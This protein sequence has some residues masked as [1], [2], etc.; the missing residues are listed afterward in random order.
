MAVNY[1]EFIGSAERIELDQAMKRI[2]TALIERRADFLF[3]AGMSVQAPSSV[4][5]GRDLAVKLLEEYFPDGGDDAKSGDAKCPTCGGKTDIPPRKFRLEDLATAL[6]FEC[7]AEAIENGPGKKRDDLTKY[8]QQLLFNREFK[9]NPAHHEFLTVFSWDGHARLRRVFTTNF[10]PLIELALGAHAVRVTEKNA[11]DIDGIQERKQVPVLHLHGVLDEDY[12]ITESDVFDEEFQNLHFRLR[13][14]L[15][16]S[17]VF[18]F[19]GYSMSD[20]DFRRLYLRHR[21][22]LKFRQQR[23][24]DAYVVGPA[25]DHYSYVLAKAVWE[26]RYAIFLPLDAESFFAG[27]KYFLDRS[28]RQEIQRAIMK[29]YG[30]KDEK[31]FDDKVNNAADILQ[32]DKAEATQF[33]FEARTKTGARE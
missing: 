29:K 7:I 5:A 1:P 33:L 4:P 20:P 8:L 26:S 14:A 24:K 28:T 2:A 9:I 18:V 22:N 13:T 21:D 23:K 15:D 31:A 17:D 6:P 3:G 30:L 32:I 16:E 10:D 25:R 11:N 12:Q 19:V 27:V